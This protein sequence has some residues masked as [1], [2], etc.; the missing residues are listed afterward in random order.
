MCLYVVAIHMIDC[1]RD[2]SINYLSIFN[3][4]ELGSVYLVIMSVLY[5]SLSLSLS[6]LMLISYLNTLT[7]LLGYI[8]VTLFFLHAIIG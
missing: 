7:I 8:V 4:A 6:M 1:E 5:A 3:S 2:A